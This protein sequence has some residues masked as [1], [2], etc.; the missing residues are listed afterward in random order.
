MLWCLP[1]QARRC[2]QSPPEKLAGTAERVGQLQRSPSTHLHPGAPLSLSLTL[3][4]RFTNVLRAKM[5]EDRFPPCL[6]P[7]SMARE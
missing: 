2:W 3:I 4:L 1:E 6:K 7:A 5:G